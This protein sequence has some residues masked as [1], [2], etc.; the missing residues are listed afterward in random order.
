MLLTQTYISSKEDVKAVPQ[1]QNVEKG[2]WH[3]HK[4]KNWGA[5]ARFDLGL[6][7]PLMELLDTTYV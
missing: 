1:S 4:D 2:V 6:S 3:N 7:R 5:T